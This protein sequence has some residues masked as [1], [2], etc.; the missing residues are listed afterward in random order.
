MPDD[1][2]EL[3]I[4][5]NLDFLRL[6]IATQNGAVNGHNLLR[7]PASGS[8]LGYSLHARF[9]GPYRPLLDG[10]DELFPLEFV[11]IAAAGCSPDGRMMK[12]RIAPLV[13]PTAGVVS[14]SEAVEAFDLAP[15]E[16]RGFT[17][18][19]HFT[20]SPAFTPEAY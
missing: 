3:C 13:T 18:R 9:T 1:T 15:G 5:T 4:D 14:L 6:R 7:D 19:I 10:A 16:R 12:V 17:D 8:M 20:F 11:P 2:L